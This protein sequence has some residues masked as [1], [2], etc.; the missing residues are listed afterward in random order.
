M[1]SIK[2]NDQVV[3]IAGKDK[4]KIGKILRVFPKSDRVIVENINMVKK[5]KRKTQQD[6]QGGFIEIETSIHISNIMLLDK[7]TNKPTRFGVSILKDGSKVRIS[8]KS[9]EVV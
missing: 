9:G 6:Q 3:V 4:G 8:K 7:K 1:L 2:K 5:A